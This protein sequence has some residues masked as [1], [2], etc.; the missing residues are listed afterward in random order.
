MTD[1]TLWWLAAGILV[2]A[3]LLTGTFYLLMLALGVAAG[4]LAAHAGLG[5]MAQ[6]LF[7]AA[8]GGGAVAVWHLKR[9]SAA[10]S[11]HTASNPDLN[12]DIGDVVHVEAWQADGSTTVRHRGAPWSAIVADPSVRL[13]GLPAESARPTGAY[14]IVAVRG[15]QLVIEPV[16]EKQSS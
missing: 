5:S 10:A 11:R 2:A 14:R 12:L 9:S 6:M 7:A 4:A 1:S 8:V 15:S 3:E 16:A 13:P